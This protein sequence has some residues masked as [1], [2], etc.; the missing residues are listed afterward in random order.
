MVSTVGR[1]TG[2]SAPRT[3]GTSRR[4]NRHRR[5]RQRLIGA[6]PVVETSIRMPGGHAVHRAHA[7]FTGAAT[8]NG[9][10][11]LVVEVENRSP[12]PFAVALAV[13]P[14]NPE[15]LALVERIGLDG[16]TDGDRGWSHRDAVATAARG[17]GSVDVQRGR[18][19]A[20]RARGRCSS[21]HDP[22]QP[23]RRSR[24]GSG[25][26]R[27]SAATYGDVAG[28]AADGLDESYALGAV[29]R[30]AVSTLRP[31]SR[32]RSRLPSR[33]RVDGRRRAGTACGSSY[34]TRRL[35]EAVDANRRFLLAL[36]DGPDITPG[37]SP[38]AGSGSVT[39]CS[40]SPRSAATATRRTLPRCCTRT[41][42]GN[43]STAC[44][45]ATRMSGT[46]TGARCGR[47]PSTGA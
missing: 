13:R 10:D 27:V 30:V 43:G 29:P 33:S 41:R 24:H 45:S 40:C 44:S 3:D 42:R 6:A 38:Y 18:Q 21:R 22:E 35:Q 37:P 46:R 36:H 39:P 16:G 25:G 8:S 14:Y 20:G 15:G 12:V 5:A 32:P 26:A 1:S 23:A 19:R 47:S 17:G 31:R 34:P 7:C 11:I 4:E 28:R 2:G 9:G